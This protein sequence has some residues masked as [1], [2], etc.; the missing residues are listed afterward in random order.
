MA[1]KMGWSLP[2]RGAWIEI[3]ALVYRSATLTS[4]PT[5]GAWIEIKSFLTITRSQR[6][7]PHTGSV[8]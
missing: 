7:A 4:L 2:T 8:D 1:S 5:R 6:V 3:L